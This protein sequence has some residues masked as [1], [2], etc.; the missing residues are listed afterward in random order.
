MAVA[1][2]KYNPIPTIRS[3]SK[4]ENELVRIVLD[5]AIG[6]FVRTVN[7]AEVVSEELSDALQVVKN[8]L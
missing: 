4:N 1:V 8:L 3:L 5:N 2:K 7:G 6:D